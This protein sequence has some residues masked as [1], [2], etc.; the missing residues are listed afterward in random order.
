MPHSVNVKE[1]VVQ[2]ITDITS[3]FACLKVSAL[4]KASRISGEIDKITIGPDSV[5]NKDVSEKSENIEN[6]QNSCNVKSIRRS[7]GSPGNNISTQ[8]GIK[9]S[10]KK[11]LLESELQRKEAVQ[12]VVE[13]HW[14]QMKENGRAIQEQMA[15]S[16]SDMAR[17]RERKSA[18]KLA[19]IM[20]EEEKIAEQEEIRRKHEQQ[21]HAQR[22]QEQK[23]ELEREVEEYRKRMKEKEELF[24]KVVSLRNDFGAKY[25]DIILHTK[26]CKD[27][28]SMALVQTSYATKLK[29]LCH[30]MEA[31]DEK[32]RSGE[33]VP[34][35]LNVIEILVKRIDEL[36]CSLKVEVER[37]NSAYEAHLASIAQEAKES[38]KQASNLKQQ[39]PES[40][41]VTSA[42]VTNDAIHSDIPDC[43][44][45]HK[46][47][48]DKTVGSQNQ[49]VPVTN[50]ENVP[51][52]NSSVNVEK[53]PT[54]QKDVELYKFVDKE[55]LQIYVKSQQLLENHTK[56]CQDLLQSANVK[57]FRFDCQK[58]INIPINA[59]SATSKQHLRD[60]YERLQSLLTGNSTPNVGQ[61]PK[62][63]AYCKS[64]LAKKIVNQGETLVSSK[65]EMAFP[66]AAVTIALW[67]EHPDFGDLLLAHFY[68]VCPFTV[69]VFIPK[70]E[71]QS[72][73]D[74]Y[75]SMGYK[76]AD[77]GT[78]EKQDKFLKR[79]SGL[80]R[81]YASLTITTQRRGV[82]KGHPYG[83]QNAWRWLAA[84]LNI[85]PR[86]DVTD[87]CAT[88]VL[89][90][91]EV[92]GHALWVAYPKQFY[93][94]LIL[95]M[96]Q[97][98]PRM[99][100]VGALIGGGP[101]VRL[102]EFL[103]SSL[104]QGSIPPPVGQLPPNF[105]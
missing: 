54:E 11:I 83:L 15:I 75:R 100:S 51:T 34:T 40:A 80:M 85:E 91:L 7:I 79:M 17:E 27:K 38:Q 5:V 14:Q 12:K 95:L 105:W 89:D 49:P 6:E 22:A 3:D 55:S 16:R 61:H 103:K 104:S 9:F 96:E 37:I 36:L 88:L 92:A 28:N 70:T 86:A 25:R 74:Y 10:A 73:E 1:E 4:G 35:D 97:Y 26:S 43:K 30:Q 50:L 19:Y 69:P 72:N 23:E 78:V 29:E 21:L 39:E 94:L 84:V 59:I 42:V 77:D 102:E 24:K 44:D 53:Q 13:R 98:Y 76:Y 66:I 71:G 18:E 57:K 47:M 32:I 41:P 93:K 8:N 60:K 81:L 56:N 58:A 67:N 65:P 90:M 68:N 33:L 64:I 62:G 46:D 87:I 48:D 20:A 31:T 2:D 101:L 99:Q 52:S 45:K 82:N 63:A